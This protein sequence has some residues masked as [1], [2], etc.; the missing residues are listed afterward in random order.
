MKLFPIQAQPPDRR[1]QRSDLEVSPA[2]IRQCGVRLL[3][4][5]EPKAVG[6]STPPGNLIASERLQFVSS[7]PVS[8]VT[9]TTASAETGPSPSST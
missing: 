3:R 2:P 7:F 1:A 6:A 4:R 8:H 5:I 9:A